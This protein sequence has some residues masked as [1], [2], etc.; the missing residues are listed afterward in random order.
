MAHDRDVDAFDRRARTYDDDLLGR[1]HR[2]I[3]DRTIALALRACPNPRRVLDVG[4]GTGLALRLLAEKL[5]G[6][7]RLTGVDAAPG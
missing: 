2:D 4:C 7:Q 1:M 3:T 6:A 5:P